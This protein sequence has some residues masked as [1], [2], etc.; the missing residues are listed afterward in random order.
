[1]IIA[2]FSI[3]SQTIREETEIAV[4]VVIVPVVAVQTIAVEV[5]QVQAVA[6]RV[7]GMNWSVPQ[8]IFCT[9]LWILLGL[10]IIWRNCLTS[11]WHGVY[12]NVNFGTKINTLILSL[13]KIIL[14]K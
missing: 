2:V 4:P 5:A 8:T 7:Q 12:D 14:I 6:I 10:N 9:A 3:L 11:L 1:M 13:N